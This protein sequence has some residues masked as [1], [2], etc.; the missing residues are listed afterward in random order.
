MAQRVGPVSGRK[1]AQ[2][3]RESPEAI[4]V[5]NPCSTRPSPA[6][7]ISGVFL[8]QRYGQVRDHVIGGYRAGA[9][10]KKDKGRRGGEEVSSIN[11]KDWK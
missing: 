4:S 9:R 8:G 10:P 11:G 6:K 2:L 7:W 3:Y 1:G 5:R